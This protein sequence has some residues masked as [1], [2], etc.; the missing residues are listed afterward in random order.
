MK[1]A[2]RPSKAHK[3]HTFASALTSQ[4]RAALKARA[5]HLKPLIQV[6]QNGLSEAVFAELQSVLQTHELVKLQLPGQS[7]ATEKKD[8]LEELEE[9]L[10]EHTFVVGRIGR[11]VILYLEKNPQDAKIPLKD[12][13]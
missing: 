6:G 3:N 4:Q 10:P 11:T 13:L 9:H 2:P 5:H 8:A 7:D 1:E 12:L